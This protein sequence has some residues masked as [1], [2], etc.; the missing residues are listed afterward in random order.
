MNQL[1]YQPAFDPF[2]TLFRFLRLREAV[3]K[4][5]ALAEE[6]FCIMDFYLL[7]P[8]RISELRL[9]PEHRRFKK[10]ATKYA[11]T[12]PYGA[13]P[14][15]RVIFSRMRNIQTAVLDTLARRGLINPNQYVLGEVGLSELPIENKISAHIELENEQQSDLIEFLKSLAFEYELLGPNGLKSRS[16]LL[17]YRYDAI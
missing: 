8:H 16:H 14:E 6:H 3:L 13:M 7:F 4:G 15:D 12:K 11:Y 17:E 1:S 10:L 9:K 2:H 5:L